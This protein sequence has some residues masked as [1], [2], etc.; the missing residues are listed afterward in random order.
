MHTHTHTHTHTLYL[1]HVI[2]IVIYYSKSK[3]LSLNI[4]VIIV[5]IFYYYSRYICMHIITRARTHTDIQYVNILIY[6][7]VVLTL[8]K[9]L[10]SFLMRHFCA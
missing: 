7:L 9:L 1:S 6:Y 4:I 2:Y 3:L 5:I 10:T 8:E